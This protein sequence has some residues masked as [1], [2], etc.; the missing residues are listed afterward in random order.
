M[1]SHSTPPTHIRGSIATEAGSKMTSRLTP[2]I[3]GGLTFLLLLCFDGLLIDNN[4]VAAPSLIANV[5]NETGEVFLS[6]PNLKLEHEPELLD[7]VIPFGVQSS[8]KYKRSLAYHGVK[9]GLP[10]ILTRLIDSLVN[11][12]EEIVQNYGQST[13]KDL[14]QALSSIRNLKN[15][16]LTNAELKP[17]R[18]SPNEN[19]TWSN[20]VRVWNNY[21]VERT[22]IE[23]V[24]PRFYST[25]YVYLECYVYRRI[26]EAFHFTETLK[27]YDPFAKQ[28]RRAFEDSTASAIAVAA[29]TLQEIDRIPEVSSANEKQQFIKH[30]KLG[31]WGNRVDLSFSHGAAVGQ[32][33]NP[34]ELL[35]G[36]DKNILIDGTDLAWNA[37][38][39]CRAKKPNG[40]ITVDIVLDNAGYELFTDLSLSA[41]L[42]ARNLADRIRFY[43]KRIP[44][45]VSD[46]TT[47]D[48]QWIIQ[49][50]KNSSNP[51][52]SRFGELLKG[53]VETGVFSILDEPFWTSP[54]VFSEMPQKD[55]ALYAKLSEASLVIF[56]GDLNYRKLFGD[57]NWEHTTSI[58]Q[59]IRGFLPTNFVSLRTLKS[60]VCVGLKPNQAES[61]AKVDPKWL[62]TAEYGVITAAVNNQT[63]SRA[64]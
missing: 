64:G 30:L 29:H 46:V 24:I 36:L 40:T 37:L 4:C 55:P 59:A 63:C 13:G 51:D 9:Y 19:D 25:I 27:F 34:L 50:M 6:S 5:S 7:T 58:L 39:N 28:K 38:V 54:F 57:I 16:I 12:R 2:T 61:I 8:P 49:H 48:F 10:R 56:K 60:D 15:E 52:L 20:E 3:L 18:F 11:D 14:D 17:L 33:G 1:Q 21:L 45:F 43:V 32:T 22:K 26:A 23:G 47:R 42:I 53:H 31:L 41:F 35:S 62:G 44:W